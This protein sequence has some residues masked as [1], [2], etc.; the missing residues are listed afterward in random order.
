MQSQMKLSAIPALLALLEELREP[1]AAMI[2][3]AS[4]ELVMHSWGSGGE[5]ISA[6][7]AADIWR[8]MIDQLR[9]DIEG[10]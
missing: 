6:E 3:A 9:R 1:S 5:F 7:S 4:N 2:E 10:G 8:A